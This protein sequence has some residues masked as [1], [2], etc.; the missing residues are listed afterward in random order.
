MTDFL[1]ADF[2]CSDAVRQNV[3]QKLAAFEAIADELPI[4]IIHNVPAFSV[5]Y[6]SRT[7]LQ[8]L[9]V[10]LDEVRRLG[11][12]Y[13]TKFFNPE[14]VAF[15]VPKFIEMLAGP[16]PRKW[17][18]F[19]QQVATG[20]DNQF[21][22]YLS[23]SRPF[24]YDETGKLLLSLTFALPLDPNHHLAEK[25]ERLMEENLMLKDNYQRYAALTKR[26]MELLR[27]IASGEKAGEISKRIHISEK[28][29]NTHRRNIKRKIGAR[30][31][32]DIIK[33][34]QAFNLV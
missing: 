9:G 1:P 26:E 22:W 3:T 19:F 15:Y 25:A 5:V 32:Y 12:E 11:S 28:T 20:R 16:A 13:Y 2:P 6:M 4:F 21:E 29:L 8:L 18:S 23:A 14:D 31:H 17:F 7:G 24:I 34:A 33:F 10:S 27:Y 30:T